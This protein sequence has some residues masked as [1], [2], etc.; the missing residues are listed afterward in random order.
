M[1]DVYRVAQQLLEDTPR[2]TPRV[3]VHLAARCHREGK[4][5]LAV[6][7]SLSENGCLLR[8]PEPLLLGTRLE[9]S[10][11]LPRSGALRLEAENAYQLL[12]D[13]GLIF[14]ATAPAHRDA[15]RSYVS[16]ALASL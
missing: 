12:P 9:L 15:I 10:F 6:V 5:W 14:H 3:P 4:E 2:S 7:L 13:F 1:H 16:D 11:D 8:T